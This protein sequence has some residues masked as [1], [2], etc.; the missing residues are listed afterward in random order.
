MVEYAYPGVYVA[1]VETGPR[2]IPGVPT[3]VS[4]FMSRE[5]IAAIGGLLDRLPPD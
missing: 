2:P 5:A 3:S 1:E 4:A